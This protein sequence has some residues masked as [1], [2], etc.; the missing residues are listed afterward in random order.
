M[1]DQFQNKKAH[2]TSVKA[3]KSDPNSMCHEWIQHLVGLRVC[4]PERWRNSQS[5]SKKI[6]E[7]TISAVNLEKGEENKCFQL[8]VF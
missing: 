2:K 8:S 3:E 6:Y 7:G 4:V 1:L 5:K